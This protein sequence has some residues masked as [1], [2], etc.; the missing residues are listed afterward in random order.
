VSGGE[1]DDMLVICFVGN[2][3]YLTFC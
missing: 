1:V 3:L 2:A